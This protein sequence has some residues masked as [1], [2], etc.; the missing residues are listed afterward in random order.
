MVSPSIESYYSHSYHHSNADILGEVDNCEYFWKL[1]HYLADLHRDIIAIIDEE[2][3]SFNSKDSFYS[4][5]R[6]I[7]LHLKY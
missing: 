3:L 5:V 6:Y 7:A 2:E 4:A 1:N